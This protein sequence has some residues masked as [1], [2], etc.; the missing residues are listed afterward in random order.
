ML[1][2]YMDANNLMKKILLRIILKG[3]YKK[4]SN[5][6]G[7]PFVVIYLRRVAMSV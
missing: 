7:R 1:S 5:G 2:N 6:G 4:H 3:D